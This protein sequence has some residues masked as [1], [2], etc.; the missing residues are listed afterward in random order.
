[1]KNIIAVL[2]VALF[3]TIALSSAPA[4]AAEP[5]HEVTYYKMLPG[6]IMKGE[7]PDRV[8]VLKATIG[9]SVPGAMSTEDVRYVLH[10]SIG[11]EIECRAKVAGKD[12]QIFWII[13]KGDKAVDILTGPEARFSLHQYGVHTIMLRA[14]NQPGDGVKYNYDTYFK[15]M[16]DY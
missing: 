8:Q 15:V 5:K 2:V 3:A 4:Q 14:T 6:V 7:H 11:G 12:V 10:A 9:G 16:I 1:M 13:S